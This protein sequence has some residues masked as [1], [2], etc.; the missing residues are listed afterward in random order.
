VYLAEGNVSVG[1]VLIDLTN[2]PHPPKGP[3]TQTLV[4]PGNRKVVGA[5]VVVQ[6]Q[7]ALTCGSVG[8]RP[9]ASAQLSACQDL[10][11]AIS[12]RAK[13][14]RNINR[15]GVCVVDAANFENRLPRAD[16]D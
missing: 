8:D 11:A 1:P 16:V 14:Q 9:G 15:H 7:Q 10:D 5:A 2:L 12:R 4:P 6:R 3:A 13:P